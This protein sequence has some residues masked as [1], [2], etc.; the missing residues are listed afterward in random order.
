[1]KARIVM[2]I[3]TFALSAL[4]AQGVAWLAR[5]DR[6]GPS[7]LSQ[8]AYVWQRAWT[9]A[10]NK[11][12][13]TTGQRFSK[14]VV[15]SAQVDWDRASPKVIRISPGYAALRSSGCEVGLALRITARK[16]PL[17]PGSPAVSALA[18]LA[19][20]LVAEAKAAGLRPV[21]FQIDY[22]CPESR[23]R[24]FAD[25]LAV[26]KNPVRPCAL[27]VTVLPC[28]LSG[29][30]ACERLLDTADAFVLQVHS[31][32][33]QP[34]TREPRL[35]D[36]RDARRAVLLAARFGHPF[37]VALPTYGYRVARDS[38]G[39]WIG[40]AAEQAAWAE[41]P[42]CVLQDVRADPAQIA[43][44]VRAWTQD[45]PAT[46]KGLIWYRLPVDGD[47]LNWAPPTLA[48][49]MKGLTPRPALAAELIRN[50]PCLFD[51][52]VNN[53]GTSDAVL[54]GKFI[55]IPLASTEVES[56]EAIGGWALARQ[57]NVLV[58]T[59]PLRMPSPR[60]KPGAST[61]TG[62][63]RLRHPAAPL[64]LALA[65]GPECP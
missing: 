64:E 26:L 33:S 58:L 11:G 31:L 60:L 5:D 2:L 24:E 54:H 13:R 46:M 59:A 21:E 1:M 29:G 57:T 47:R 51:V 4:L 49:V 20:N 36:S 45:H 40:V 42:G 16:E 35:L 6:S 32:S 65:E 17:V 15:L 62:W 7:P 52:R 34:G 43:E 30:D 10:V 41:P 9:P 8:A 39:K 50:D 37:E 22:D 55:R 25:W 27:T 61:T 53:R 19:S 63:I 12:V 38:E 28:W 14:L 44:L 23:L 18:A 56:A 3:S 48:C